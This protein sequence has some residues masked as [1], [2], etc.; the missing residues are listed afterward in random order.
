MIDPAP[1]ADPVP[2]PPRLLDQLRQAVLAHFGR[3]EPG[4]RASRMQ[5]I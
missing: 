2:Q 5:Y 3:P 1:N 4:V